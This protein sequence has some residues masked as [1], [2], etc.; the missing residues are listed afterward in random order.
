[1]FDALRVLNDDK[2]K[3]ILQFELIKLDTSFHEMI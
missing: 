1:M 2:G 3:D